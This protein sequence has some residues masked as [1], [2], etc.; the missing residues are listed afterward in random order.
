MRKL[1]MAVASI[2]LGLVASA[3]SS[4]P[5][6]SQT[7][8][9]LGKWCS[10]FP[11]ALEYAES[12]NLPL[13]VFWANEGCSQCAKL[14]SACMEP[15]FVAWQSEKKIVMVFAYNKETS[16][17]SAAKKWIKKIASISNYP[18]IGVYWKAN[19]ANQKVEAAFVGRTG[20]MPSKSGSLQQQ[21]MDSVDGLIAGWTPGSSD[22]VVDPDP[23]GPTPPPKDDP[24]PTLQTIF[25]KSQSFEALV[26]SKTSD[27]FVGTAKI[28]LGKISKTKGTVKIS[29]RI[30]PF[31]GS[32]TTANE[33]AVPAA[34]GSFSGTLA[35][36]K[37]FGS[38]KYALAYDAAS[39]T[40]KFSAENEDY[41]ISVGEYTLGGAFESDELS[42]YADF[43][44][45]VE[46]PEG[47][48]FE[49]DPPAGEPIHVKNGTK[50]SCDKATS[51]KVKKE[52]GDY[53]VEH[54]YGKNDDKTNESGLKIS[55]KSS[56]GTFSGS[57]KI[58]ASMDDGEKKPT[59]KS[60]TAKFSGVVIDQAG[61]GSFSVKIG[62]KTYTG[63][64]SFE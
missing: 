29:V 49:V 4:D 46:L 48:D 23:V 54:D 27:A 34:D 17:Q 37:T 13:L 36:K 15:D 25:K 61:S 3:A 42:F 6:G 19:T 33:T 26:T 10:D 55:Y 7:K 18:F 59:L 24:D 22:P 52:D 56:N 45:D 9:E 35:Y 2:A 60:Y 11:A 64:C 40:F 51:I 8:V 12:N 50:F 21:L 16:P 38:L 44:D 62:K 31:S 63:T 53:F 14:E 1:I 47:Y 30:S 58:Y 32:A 41:E 20:M 5:M 43:T 28:T 57:F 39:K